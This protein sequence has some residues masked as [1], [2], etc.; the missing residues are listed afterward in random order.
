MM[1]KECYPIIRKC[2][3]VEMIKTTIRMEFNH[4]DFKLEND[5]E[6]GTNRETT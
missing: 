4:D 1:T 3:I 2:F 6:I 5:S